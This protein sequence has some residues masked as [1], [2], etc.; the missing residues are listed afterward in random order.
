MTR[1]S[2]ETFLANRTLSTAKSQQA[3]EAIS[4]LLMAFG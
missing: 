3:H 4:N 1:E 2:L